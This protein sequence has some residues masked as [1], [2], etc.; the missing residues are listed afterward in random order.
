MDKF[1][2]HI[3]FLELSFPRESKYHQE[4]QNG[5]EIINITSIIGLLISI[6]ISYLNYFIN[7][8][9]RWDYLDL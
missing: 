6:V 2:F 1:T 5:T 4:I 7:N 9:N 8:Q 3:H